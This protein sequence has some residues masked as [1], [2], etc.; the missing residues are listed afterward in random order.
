MY[1]DCTSTLEEIEEL[2][3]TCGKDRHYKD[4]VLGP[5]EREGE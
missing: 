2:L 4:C 3:C 5:V 1:S